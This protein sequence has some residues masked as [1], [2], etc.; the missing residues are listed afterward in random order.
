MTMTQNS[1]ALAKRESRANTR[2]SLADTIKD[3]V[4]AL[5]ELAALYVESGAFTDVKSV[6]Q[7][8]VK[9]KTGYDLGFRSPHIALAGIH[10]I[11]GKAVIGAN[12]LASLIK[13]SGRYD[14]RITKHTDQECEVEFYQRLHDGQ[15]AKMGVPVSYTMQ[16]AAKAQLTGKDNWKKHPKAMLFAACI[17]QGARY[18]CADVLRGT[19]TFSN[20]GMEEASV[21]ADD[22]YLQATAFGQS[23][24][25]VDGHE[26]AEAI[27]QQQRE[28]SLEQL[29]QV[30]AD[31]NAAGDEPKWS[32]K[33]INEYADET[34]Q[35]SGGIDALNAAAIDSL[36][37]TLLDRLDSLRNR[38]SDDS[39][40]I[41]GEVVPEPSDPSESSTEDLRI[42]AKDWYTSADVADKRKADEW[43]GQRTIG[44]LGS[45]D[46][47]A[48]FD[49]FCG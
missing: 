13:D 37:D 4:D 12:L 28:E 6:A 41:D 32:N 8:F 29:R 35:S 33:R 48:F 23:P 34:L 47:R 49:T 31:L 42:A 36:R 30:C 5:K 2:L 27:D 21:D 43:L 14:Y 45:D 10:F 24:N 38:P 44:T 26:A 39:G 22:P 15:W 1:T 9:I 46:L 25:I 16:D 40:V 7:A 19:P 3:E 17:R 18:Y 11:Q 20:Y